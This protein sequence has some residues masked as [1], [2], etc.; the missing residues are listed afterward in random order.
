MSLTIILLFIPM[1]FLILTL[2]Y[3]IRNE[4]Y[5]LIKQLILMILISP[6][7]HL[8]GSLFTYPYY[9]IQPMS[10]LVCMPIST[11]INFIINSIGAKKFIE[12][13]LI[14]DKKKLIISIILNFLFTLSVALYLNTLL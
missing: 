1:I 3:C 12:S 14:L 7:I 2:I 8:I 10:I 11:I 13:T 4:N 5:K 9:K 6:I